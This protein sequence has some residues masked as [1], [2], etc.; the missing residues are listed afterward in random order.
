MAKPP[1]PVG[2][3]RVNARNLSSDM[4]M[5]RQLRDGG[6][7]KRAVSLGFVANLDHVPLGVADFKELGVAPVLNRSDKHHCP[8]SQNHV[9]SHLFET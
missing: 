4:E 3:A 2:S 5:L 1:F 9:N 7:G 6:D 8:P